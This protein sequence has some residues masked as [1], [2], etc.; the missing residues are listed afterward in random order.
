M[1]KRITIRKSCFSEISSSTNR[2]QQQ[3]CG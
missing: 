2:N 3:A 1:C